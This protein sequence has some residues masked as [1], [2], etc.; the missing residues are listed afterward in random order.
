MTKETKVHN[1]TTFQGGS[2]ESPMAV[3]AFL[4]SY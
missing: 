4:L 2:N 1:N 3:G